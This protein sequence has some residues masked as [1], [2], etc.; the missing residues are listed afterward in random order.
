VRSRLI[1]VIG[2]L[3]G[4]VSLAQQPKTVTLTD[5]EATKIEAAN[6]KLQNLQ[7]QFQLTQSQLQKLQEQYP[8]IQKE[9]N[10]ATEAA[11]AAHKLGPDAALSQDGKSF[12][13]QE[14]PAAA[15]KK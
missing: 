4:A 1:V 13:V 7:L 15:V 9:L 6:L 8:A 10:D 5:A 12:A 14:K 2:L 11:R 3:A